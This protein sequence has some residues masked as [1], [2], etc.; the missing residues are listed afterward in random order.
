MNSA[1]NTTASP[2]DSADLMVGEILR[3]ARLKFNLSPQDVEHQL[4]IRAIHI[5]ALEKNDLARLPGRVY[6]VGFVR[7]YAEY[8]G[9]DGDRMAM[10]FKEQAVHASGQSSAMLAK[11]ELSFPVS[12]D[13]NRVPDWRLVLGCIAALVIVT[14]VF[15]VFQSP[16]PATDVPPVPEALTK[17]LT[18]ASAPDVS[19]EAAPAAVAAAPVKKAH[20]IVLKAV[21]NVWLEIRG[22]DG[23]ALFSRVLK[24]GEEYWVPE[25]QK[26]L[27]MTTGNAGGLDIVVNGQ[28]IPK[29]GAVGDVRRNVPLDVARLAPVSVAPTK[30]N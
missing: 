22:P 26:G 14:V 15:N 11:P 21:D 8:L 29:L 17:T 9:L 25:D 23:K 4:R 7:T 24:G 16:V 2:D 12:A 10:L 6:A 13:E 1:F 3:R 27:V 30:G 28:S 20:P 5:E 18:V 19:A